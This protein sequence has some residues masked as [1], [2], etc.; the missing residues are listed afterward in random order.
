MSTAETLADLCLR[1]SDLRN[2]EALDGREA[3][4]RAEA[5]R[6]GWTVHRVVVEN[7][8]NGGGKPKPASAY[9]RVK[10]TIDGEEKWRVDRPEFRSVIAD[11]MA[12]RASAV[13]AE[14]LDR[15]ARDARD[16]EDVIDC[17]ERKGA[18]IRS[19]SSGE[20]HLEAGDGRAMAR[21]VCAFSR[22]ESEDKGR[23][24]ADARERL[25]GQSYG[26]GRR[27][28]GYRPDPGAPKDHK[29]LILVGAEAALIRQA[30]PDIP[31]RGLTPQAR[32]PRPPEWA[33]RP[34]GR[35]CG[36]AWERAPGRP[37]GAP[38]RAGPT[39]MSAGTPGRWAPWCRG[40]WWTGGACPPRRT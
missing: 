18:V 36:A 4:L 32:A 35:G 16:L 24:V 31:D 14:D 23:R 15:L 28:Y 19:L 20:I 13:L 26:G 38:T 10:I 17:A 25:A 21:V 6:L 11:L 12:R 1:L 9:K 29:K 27:P 34:R 30:P 5:G 40:P 2:E 8:L 39:G 33:R 22:K 7:D 37:P 3:K